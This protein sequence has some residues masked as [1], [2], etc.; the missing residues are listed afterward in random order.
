MM[1]AEALETALAAPTGGDRIFERFLAACRARPEATAIVSASGTWT[2]AQLERASRNLA[3]QLLATPGTDDVVALYARRSGELVV[4][5][6][7]CLRAGLTFAVLDAE[8]P[9]ERLALLLGVLE[10]GRFVTIGSDLAPLAPKA[11]VVPLAMQA[12]LADDRTDARI[13]QGRADAVAYLMFTSGTTGVPK[14]IATAHAPLVHFID[15]YERTL[16]V[17]ER[18]R[19]S[20]LSGL[21]HD[22]ILRDVFV[23]LSTGA[24]LHV[25]PHTTVLDPVKLYAWLGEARI[26]HAHVTPQLSRIV[27][28]GRRDQPALDSLAFVCSGGDTLRSKQANEL[29]GVAP[30]VR[31][32]NFYGAT[33]TPQ[34]MGFHVFDPRTDTADA[35]PIG[36]G[37]ADVQLLVLDDELGVAEPG[38]RGQIAIRT[39]Y[40]SAGYRGDAAL[41]H[42]RFVANP[43]ASDPADR[44]YLTG[45]L[46]RARSDGAVSIEGRLDDQVKIRGFRVELGDVVAQLQK[47][48]G[49]KEA[50]VLAERLPDGESRLVAYLVGSGATGAVRDAMTAAAPPYMVPGRYVWLPAFPLLPNGKIDRAALAKLETVDDAPA[51][52]LDPTEATIVANWRA[53]LAQPQ[54]DVDSNFVDLGGDSLSFIEASVQLEQLLG[55]LPDK[56]ERLSIR[57]LAR[58]KQARKSR[59]A[60][61][62]SSVL[63]RAISIV[64]VVIGHYE[65]PNLAGTVIALFVVSGMSF[66]KY[67]APQIARTQRITPIVRLVVKIAIPTILYSILVNVFFHLPKWPGILMVNNLVS[68]DSHVSGIGFWYID[69]LVQCFVILGA[70][71]AVPPVRRLLSGDPFAPLIG[72]TL[73]FAGIAAIAPFVV[74][75]SHLADRVPHHFLGAVFLG[76][77]LIHAETT[78]RKVIVALV[79]IVTFAQFA[80]E[81][82]YYLW[83]P[84]VA[85]GFVLLV[86]RVSLPLYLSRL[87]N[88]VASASLFIYL[89]D[90][91]VGWAFEKAHLAHH[92]VLMVVTAVI[93]GI[94]GWKLW[95]LV[96]AIAL[97]L[98]RR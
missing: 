9:V 35:V 75:T 93:V 60:T 28:A 4:G 73:V 78:A 57:E 33:E 64:G 86:Q 65:L 90:H 52:A 40:L 74:D 42:K 80:W 98:R 27:C 17:T 72:A 39:H 82:E 48:A 22:P 41:T 7:A 79:T 12:L 67:L 47:L 54:I 77:A 44:L 16:A 58:A 51:Q 32:V 37:I 89:T 2:Y 21:G 5:M 8:Y 34:A 18:S 62:D 1:R 92:G 95:D 94:V 83:F 45:D 81:S 30:G 15:W 59:W 25:P 85:T 69:V 70:L 88:I 10:P 53:L 76:W 14:C 20:M 50:V 71:L 13:D 6:L 84:F 26:T 29:I 66:G 36:R 31:V 61:V 38:A 91:Q 97:R 87:V 19:F 96:T 46:G 56:W 3:A 43:R 63:L 55:K 24:Q 23:P 11:P 68:A 49:V